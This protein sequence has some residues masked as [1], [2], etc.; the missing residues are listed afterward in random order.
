MDV[1]AFIVL[2]VIAAVAEMAAVGVY[3]AILWLT[4]AQ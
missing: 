1:P 4:V 3:A 2:L